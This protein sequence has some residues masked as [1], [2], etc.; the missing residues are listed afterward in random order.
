M[1]K[2]KNYSGYI[3]TINQNFRRE[4]RE[5]IIFRL[6]NINNTFFFAEEIITGCLF[7]ICNFAKNQKDGISFKEYSY[8]QKIKN[9]VYLQ[10]IFNEEVFKYHISELHEPS[11]EELNNYFIERKP[12][13]GWLTKMKKFEAENLFLC[14]IKLIKEKLPT[15]KDSVYISNTDLKEDIEWKEVEK[16]GYDLSTQ[17]NL[18][19]L[20]GRSEEIKKIIKALCI[21]GKSVILVG[22]AGSGKTSIVEKLAL[23]IQKNPWLR[24]KMIFSVSPSLLISGTKYRGDLEENINKLISFCKN[25]NGNIILF[26]DEIHTLYGLGRTDDSSIDAMNILKPYLSNG[27][28]T[29]IGAT[30]KEEY[31][32]YLA[33]DPAFIRRIEKIDIL[34]PDHN[35]NIQILEFYIRELEDKYNI[36]IHLDDNKL[37]YIIEYILNITDPQN[38]KVIGDVKIKNPTLAKSI[39]ENA[40]VEAIYNRK[41]EVTISDICFAIIDCDKLSPTFRKEK[42][43]KLESIITSKQKVSNIIELPLTKTKRK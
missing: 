21:R 26:I 32:N 2:V 37:L 14:D 16:F 6:V 4:T 8:A 7:P 39:I 42:A 43:S 12:S 31:T 3:Y 30:T 27:D 17:K 5:K 13:I 36:R 18:C 38:Q 33:R 41:Q 10:L 20:V 11:M 19:N 9:F 25:N 15:I 35:L 24:G 22:E 40:F 29:L 34:P 1:D 23:D 28:I